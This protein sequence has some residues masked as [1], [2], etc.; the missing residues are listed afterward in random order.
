[1]NFPGATIGLACDH[2]GVAL[3][4]LIKPRLEARGLTYKDF[5][6]YTAE[7]CDYPDFA[8]PLGRAIADGMLEAGIAI[9]GTGNGMSI[10]LNKYPCIRAG[11]AWNREIATLVSSLKKANVLVQPARYITEDE[12]LCSVDAWLDAPF[13]GEQH[14]VRI[15]KILRR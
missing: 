15:R 3:K 2:T 14:A 4:E 11:L 1:M 9:C 7:R 10:V 12:A 8:H 13:A 5:G 6:A